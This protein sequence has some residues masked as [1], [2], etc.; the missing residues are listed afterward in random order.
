MRVLIVKT[1]SMGDLIHTLPALTDAKRNIPDITFDWVVEEA[2]AEIPA[3]HP[4]VDRVIPVSLRKWRKNIFKRDTH[5][6]LKSLKNKLNEQKYD[7]ILDAQGLV[8]SALINFLANGTRVGLDWQSAREPLASL[9]YQRKCKV[10]FYQHAIIRMRLLFSLALKYPP[11]DSPPDFG[12]QREK[13]LDPSA[14]KYLVLLH[15]TTWVTKQWPESYWEKL[16]KLAEKEFKIY[17]GG[18]SASEIARAER[19]ASNL[20]NVELKPYLSISA[21]AKLLANASGA[22]AVDTGFGHLAAALNIPTVSIYGATNPDYTGALGPYSEHLAADFSC[23]PCLSREC[24]Y[25]Q[26]ASVTPACYQ[27][28]TPERVLQTL[29]QI[30]L[31]HQSNQ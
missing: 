12:I 15:G 7:L 18:G 2:Y 14:E 10:N 30:I 16:A 17:I 31:R 13:L 27:S 24:T 19:I 23:S 5:Q 29:R 8:K 20:K 21:M 9:V 26:A 11:P 22:V 4:A 3:W 1:S 28:I 25:K 6:A